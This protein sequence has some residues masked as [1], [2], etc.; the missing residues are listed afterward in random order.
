MK[1]KSSTNQSLISKLEISLQ[2]AK[3]WI[4]Q[5]IKSALTICLSLL[6]KWKSKESKLILLYITHKKVSPK[7]SIHKTMDQSKI[8][9]DKAAQQLSIKIHEIVF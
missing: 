9:F 6:R 2:D 5:L 4:D 3:S 8:L 7:M 1:I